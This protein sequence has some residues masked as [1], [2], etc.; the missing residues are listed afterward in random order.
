MNKLFSVRT[1]AAAAIIVSPFLTG[2]ASI[3]NGTNQV[4]SVEAR[5]NGEMLSGATC[6]LVNG[7]GVFY[8]T[9]PGTVTVHRAYDDLLV[10]CE[11]ENA[12]PGLATVKSSTKGMAFGNILFGGVIGAAVDTGSGAAYDY[13]S[14]ITVLMG[15]NTQVQ[16]KPAS[17]KSAAPVSTPRQTAPSGGTGQFATATVKPAPIPA[18]IA[19]SNNV[20]ALADKTPLPP[21]SGFADISDISKLDQFG[22]RAGYERFLHQSFPRAFAIAEGGGGWWISW[23]T[24]PKDPT[25]SPEPLI[26]VIP[27]CEKHHKRRCY[28]YAADGIV[29]YQEPKN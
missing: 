26:R 2:C 8:V 16:T 21:A 12:P 5:N 3:V 14:L 19:P 11:K 13:P 24:K 10:K 23:G 18:A 9:T 15:E 29:V 28:L 4:V 25:A 7:K 27:D 1:L 22:A 20:P 6:K 17:A